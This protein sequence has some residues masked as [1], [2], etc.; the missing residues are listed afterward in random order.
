MRCWKL[1]NLWVAAF[2]AASLGGACQ[3]EPTQQ[4]PRFVPATGPPPGGPQGRSAAAQKAPATAEVATAKWRKEADQT[5]AGDAPAFDVTLKGYRS[6][7][8]MRTLKAVR[9]ELDMSLVEAVK[10]IE[11]LPQPLGRGLDKAEAVAL[12][13]RFAQLG[14]TLEVKPGNPKP[15]PKLAAGVFAAAPRGIDGCPAKGPE[16]ARVWLVEFTDYQ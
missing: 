11:S 1:S 14:A 5:L 8:K 9:L 15:R 6:A 13:S 12:V 3:G 7:A 10:F 16:H 2:L 4:G